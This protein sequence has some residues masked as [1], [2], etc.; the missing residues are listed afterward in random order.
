VKSRRISRIGIFLFVAIVAA[1]SG[2][3][4]RPQ[5]KTPG[6]AA[7][8]PISATAGSTN[9]KALGSK[10]APVTIEVFEDFECPACR[11]FFQTSLKQVVEN[12]VNTGKVYLIH[13]DFPLE[14]HPYARQAARLANAAADLGQFE[15]VERA[16][17]DTQDKWSTNG[18]IEDAIAPSVPAAQMKK[19]RDYQAAHIEEINASIERD[20]AMGVQRNVNQTPTIY[21]TS[22]GKTEALPGGGVDYKLLKQYLDFLLRQ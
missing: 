14:M 7:A 21:V 10:N 1:M 6:S 4:A 5:T 13:R 20:R 11:N 18:K 9:A 17:F 2:V 3:S 22:R 8:K 15:T 12:Y 19:I 16:L